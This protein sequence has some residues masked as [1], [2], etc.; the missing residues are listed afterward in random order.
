MED[1][2]QRNNQ[3]QDLQ[4]TKSDTQ[5]H[6]FT[7]F[8]FFYFYHFLASH[9]TAVLFVTHHKLQQPH[10][11]SERAQGQAHS[12]CCEPLKTAAPKGTSRQMLWDCAEQRSG[13]FIEIFKVVAVPPH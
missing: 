1:C 2:C 7:C 9:R 12:K 11:C 5:L 13:V 10:P 3:G 4:I 8:L 6:S